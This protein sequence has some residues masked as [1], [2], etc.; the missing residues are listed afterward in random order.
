VTHGSAALKNKETI[1]LELIKVS[2]IVYSRLYF[3]G[4]NICGD[5]NVNNVVKVVG[6]CV[7]SI[8]GT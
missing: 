3:K 4:S 8:M 6:V 5:A 7:R 1:L 2:L